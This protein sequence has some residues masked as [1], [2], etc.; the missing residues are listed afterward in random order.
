MW[1]L[2][3]DLHMIL[4]DDGGWWCYNNSTDSESTFI[5]DHSEFMQQ[6][7]SKPEAGIVQERETEKSLN[8]M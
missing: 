7:A 3:S 6:Y 4:E 8:E 1:L 5:T 2:S